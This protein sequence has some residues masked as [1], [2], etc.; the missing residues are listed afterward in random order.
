LLTKGTSTI[1]SGA[2]LLFVGWLGFDPKMPSA[3][4]ASAF[5]MVS[6][7]LPAVLLSAAAVMACRFPLDRRRHSTVVRAL[8]RRA[9][10]ARTA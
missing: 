2:G 7:A 6:L 3:V 5:K 10:N 9:G 8:A 1:G 4:G